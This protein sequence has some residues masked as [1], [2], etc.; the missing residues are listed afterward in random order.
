M[1]QTCEHAAKA[2]S[3]HSMETVYRPLRKMCEQALKEKRQLQQHKTTTSN[4]VLCKCVH[5]FCQILNASDF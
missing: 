2:P 5:T 3:Q 4:A 1:R